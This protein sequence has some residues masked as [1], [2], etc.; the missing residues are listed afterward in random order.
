MFSDSI[1][2]HVYFRSQY[3]FLI[4]LIFKTFYEIVSISRS[5]TIFIPFKSMA[6]RDKIGVDRLLAEYD[7]PE[8]CS[9]FIIAFS[10]C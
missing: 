2:N 10:I 1:L 4:F 5:K 9:Q 3:P 6:Y 7:P 8:V